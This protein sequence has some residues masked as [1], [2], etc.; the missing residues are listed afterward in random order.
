METKLKIE[1]SQKS[2]N[3]EDALSSELFPKL[4]TGKSI[5][6]RIKD[7][8]NLVRSTKVQESKGPLAIWGETPWGKTSWGEQP[9]GSSPWGNSP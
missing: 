6:E 9:W 8:K 1:N 7:I 5:S 4:I 3:V 2:K